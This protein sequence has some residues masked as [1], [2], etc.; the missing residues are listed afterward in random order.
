MSA[1]KT[2][3]WLD[4]IAFPLQ[5][6]FPV[7]RQEILEHVGGYLD[8]AG[9]DAD[10]PR[11][12]ESARRKFERDKDELRALGIEI[13][14]VQLPDHAG[15][16]PAAG[17]RLRARDF[18]LPY[19]EFSLADHAAERP[20]VRC[21]YY[22]I[23]RDAQSMPDDGKR[24]EAT[25]GELYVTPAPRGATEPER[26]LDRLPVRLGDRVLGE[27]ALEKISDWPG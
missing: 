9:A 22:S 4:L 12:I 3:R 7:T 1:E 20:A 26:Y 21:T 11:A 2:T 14:T 23:G 17:Y 6:R 27:I 25:G 8:P 15:D 5:H 16:E 24:Y 19:L 18:Y 13:E 10:D